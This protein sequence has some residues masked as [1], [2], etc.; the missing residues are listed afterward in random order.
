MIRW[1]L[2]RLSKFLP[3]RVIRRSDGAVYLRRF[4][5]CGD[6]SI[7]AKYFPEG[8]R[9]PRWWQRPFVKFPLVYLH[10]FESSDVDLELHNHPW[11]AK[12]LILAGG[13]LEERRCEHASGAYYVD[14]FPR[15]P[16]Q[17]NALRADTFHRVLLFERDC[18]TLIKVGERVQTWGFWNRDTGIFIHWKDMQAHR[19]AARAAKEAADKHLREYLEYLEKTPHSK[20]GST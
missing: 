11:E 10:K 2:A 7:L 9:E 16:G 3:E 15:R 17:V 8:H 18:W 6:P 13:Y 1:L 12:A 20:G 5:L 14:R 4:Y 19:E